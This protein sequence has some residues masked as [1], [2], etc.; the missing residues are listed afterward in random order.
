[1]GVGGY[2]TRIRRRMGPLCH[3]LFAEKKEWGKEREKEKG[4]CNLESQQ[5]ITNIIRSI[6]GT[7]IITITNQSCDGPS[8]A[9]SWCLEWHRHHLYC[10]HQGRERE[11]HVLHTTNRRTNWN[12]NSSKR[13]HQYISN[14]IWT[15]QFVSLIRTN[16]VDDHSSSLN[17][18]SIEPN[19]TWFEG[20]KQTKQNEMKINHRSVQ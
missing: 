11:A 13:E 10:P 3:F 1:M 19:Q 7:T 14:L 12:P 18:E 2:S 5:S 9:A 20:I 6:G 15:F 8:T 17:E 4:P 16:Q